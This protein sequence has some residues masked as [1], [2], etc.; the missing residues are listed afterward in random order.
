MS[1][2]ADSTKLQLYPVNTL[3]LR[4]AAQA[5]IYLKT[6]TARPMRG[7]SPSGAVCTGEASTA[8]AT[9]ILRCSSACRAEK[10]PSKWKPGNAPQ[11]VSTNDEGRLLVNMDLGKFKTADNQKEVQAG[12]ALYY[13]FQLEYG[14]GSS[15]EYYPI[16]LRVDTSMNLDDIA[17]TGDSIV[18]WEKNES[19]QK[20]PYIAQQTVKYSQ[21]ATA[22]VGD[23]RK[24]TG[25]VGPSTILPHAYVT[26]SV[27]WWGDEHANDPGRST[28]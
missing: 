8:R 12:E 27:M 4:R 6:R 15:A 22:N 21:S 20:Q 17:A 1:S 14:D 24:S 16:M 7:R 19:G 11:T 5:E 13:L 10:D 26:I 3:R 2:E 18:A 9:E 28:P 23:I 25:N